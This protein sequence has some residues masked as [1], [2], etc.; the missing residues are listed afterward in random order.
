MGPDCD[1]ECTD[2]QGYFVDEDDGDVKS[3]L[4]IPVFRC[5]EEVGQDSYKAWFGYNNPNPNNV[6]IES[7]NENH[8]QDS[9][10][11]VTG[12]T[13]PTKFI[14]SKYGSVTYAFEVG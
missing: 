1:I 4:I 8:V 6:Y 9:T 5:L 11:V 3:V 2:D 12:V 14:A 13:P 10:R 7:I